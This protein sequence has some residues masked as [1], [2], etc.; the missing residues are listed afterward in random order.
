MTYNKIKSSQKTCL[1]NIYKCSLKVLGKINSYCIIKYNHS[2][3]TKRLN[4]L[5]V[6]P[7]MH[8]CGHDKFLIPPRKYWC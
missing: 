5:L 3:Q 8:N 4:G 6:G 2:F 1:K 7:K